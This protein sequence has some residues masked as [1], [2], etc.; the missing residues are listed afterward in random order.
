MRSG[1]RLVSRSPVGFLYKAVEK[2]DSFV[3]PAERDK[4]SGVRSRKRA[5]ESAEVLESLRTRY[6]EERGAE[7][8]RLRA[9]VEP[10]LLAGMRLVVEQ[11]LLKLKKLIS[12]AHFEQAIEHGLEE[13]LA[14]LFALPDF[15]EWFKARQH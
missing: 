14:R 12:P 8:K 6:L 2:A 4:P 13:K 5:E 10:Q 1:S 3:L 15:E 7:L 11:G 9:D